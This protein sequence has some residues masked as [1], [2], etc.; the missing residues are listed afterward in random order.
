MKRD[1]SHLFAIFSLLLAVS[2]PSYGQQPWSGILAPER[3]L[4]WTKAGIPG[5]IPL[6]TTV[7]ASLTAGASSSSI[8]TAIN[9]CPEGQV[10]SFGAGTFNLSGSLH[11]AKGVV[12]RGQGPNSTTLVLNNG[13]IL[14]GLGGSGQGRWAGSAGQV[15]W[16]GGLTRGSTVLTVSSTSNL[17]AGQ[18][19]IIDENNPAWVF[20]NA[21]EGSCTS[22]NS[23]GRNDNPPGF[24]G[25]ANRAATQVTEIVSVDSATQI[26]IKDPVGYTHTA[27]LTPQV[28]YWSD[29]GKPGP[30][31]RYAGVE[32][33][34]IDANN[35][36]YAISFPFCDYCWVK[37]VWIQD[38]ARSAVLFYY[39]Y[40][41]VVRDSYFTSTKTGAPTQYGLE[42]VMS[43]NIL[44]E[45]NIL[46]NI[47]TAIL[48]EDTYNLVVGYNYMDNT[49][50]G[51]LFANFSAHLAHSS[52]QLLEGNSMNQLAYDNSWG[53]ASHS[54]V[55]RNRVWGTGKN[56]TSYT[57]GI[58]FYMHQRFMN[59]VANAVGDPTYHTVYT[60][61]DLNQTGKDE[62]NDWDLGGWNAC[63]SHSQVDSVVRTSLMRWGNWDAVT[64]KANGNTNGVRYCTGNAAG[65]PACTDSETGSADPTFPAL[66]SPATNLPASFYNGVT[67]AYASCGTGLSFW[68]N[69]S[70]GTCPPYPPIGP[71]VTCTTNCIANTAN[72]AAMIPAQVC[73]ANG[74][75]DSGGFLT[76]FDAR[77]CYASDGGSVTSNTT[78]EAPSGLAAL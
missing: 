9:N 2:T 65:N 8:Q 58:K 3:A 19:I 44:Y 13:N 52:F 33:M 42:S 57:S 38:L 25:S 60:C 29:G 56:K 72:H 46:F 24:A 62:R 27:G 78:P 7:C 54:T 16:T 23:C 71:D 28:F 18:T 31:A 20:T 43:S 15:S 64:W 4:D 74:T 36:D 75:K 77:A 1:Y 6:R 32:D 49:V 47:T 37:N 14:F 22:G 61:D 59:A 41:G 53:S 11:A 73:Y 70:T 67:A 68:K 76:A 51:V 55:F 66:A 17:H 39:S 45:N 21:V 50:P 5:G 12:L 63:G 30:F 34:K 40:G 48:P 35:N 69:P 26:T 10:V